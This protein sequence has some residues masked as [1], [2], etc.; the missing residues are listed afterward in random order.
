MIAQP[1]VVIAAI[2]S[3]VPGLLVAHLVLAPSLIGIPIGLTVIVA[4]EEPLRLTHQVILFR[5]GRRA[6][7]D[8]WT[9]R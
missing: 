7:G 4:V 6:K 1:L 2:A 9:G 3:V 5:M 8:D